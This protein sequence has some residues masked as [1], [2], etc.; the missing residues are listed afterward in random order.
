MDKSKVVLSAIKMVALLIAG[1]STGLII[2]VL[3]AD[4]LDSLLITIAIAI[5]SVSTLA[6]LK[7]RELRKEIIVNN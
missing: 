5:F 1:L 2:T 3:K 7:E 4:V 6:I